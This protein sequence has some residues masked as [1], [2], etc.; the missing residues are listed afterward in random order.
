[1]RL[2]ELQA[3]F[4]DGIVQT[5]QTIVDS[6]KDSRRTDRATLFAVYYN[7]YRSR[8]SEFLSNDFP[9]LR[10]HLGEET[11]GQL[12]ED[13]IQTTPSRQPNARWYGTRLPDF[14][15]ERPPW[16]TNK[17]AIDLAEFERALSTAFD[18][19][20]APTAGIGSLRATRQSEWPQFTFDFHPSVM[21]LD[22]GGGTAQ[23]YQTLAEEEQP[24]VLRE[25]TETILFWRNDGQSFYRVVAEDERLALIEAMQGKRFGEIC[26]LLAFR[27]NGEGVTQRAAGFLSHWFADGL[28]SRWS[29]SDAI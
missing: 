22:L 13:Y 3:R 15:R 11:F 20:D 18:A 23:F 16:R 21:L 24:P 10:I 14:M 12:V 9:I 7:A 29:I 19:A 8:L 2:A 5:E 26:A 17:I 1:M 25:G 27:K 6:I 28:I 4:Q